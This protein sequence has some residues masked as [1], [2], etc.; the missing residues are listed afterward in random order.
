MGGVGRVLSFV[1]CLWVPVG[2]DALLV[3]A[4]VGTNERTLG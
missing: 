3:V 1:D 4:T 2:V